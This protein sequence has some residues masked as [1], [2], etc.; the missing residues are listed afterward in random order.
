MQNFPPDHGNGRRV[1]EAARQSARKMAQ[2]SV[3]RARCKSECRANLSNRR[4]VF[5]PSSELEPCPSYSTFSSPSAGRVLAL[6]V[7]LVDAWPSMTL[8]VSGW[9]TPTNKN[10]MVSE[11][12]SGPDFRR[13][14]G[15]LGSGRR[16]VVQ[17]V[18]LCLATHRSK[19]SC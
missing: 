9:C 19:A 14:I 3:S 13:C 6:P 11:S 10:F 4:T 15:L 7:C 8:R 16:D 18:G 17:S 12:N 1:C 2:Q 5:D